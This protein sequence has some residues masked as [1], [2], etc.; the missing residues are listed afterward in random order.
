MTPRHWLIKW[1]PFHTSWEE[2]ITRGSFTLCGIRSQDVRKQLST[3][4]LGDQVLFF[5]SRQE[6]AV[7]GILEV[8]RE[9]YPGPHQHRSSLADRVGEV[10]NPVLKP[11][12][13]AV[14]PSDGKS[15]RWRNSAQ[16]ARNTMVNDDGRMKKTKNGIWEI[17]DK[18]RKWL[19]EFQGRI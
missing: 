4:R 11:L 1:A 7:M 19:K 10:M 3:M 9:A 2:I 8:I 16:W 13:S 15:I 14:L 12:D 6:R 17:S 5:H 18:G